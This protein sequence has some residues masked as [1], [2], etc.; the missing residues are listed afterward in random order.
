MLEGFQKFKPIDGYQI[1]FWK[2]SS[3]E[4][5]DED[6]GFCAACTLCLKELSFCGCHQKT[7]SA[8][9]GAAFERRRHFLRIVTW[10]PLQELPMGAI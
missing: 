10:L 9:G 6:E 3:R 5:K 8:D 2:G 1:G 4:S 7:R